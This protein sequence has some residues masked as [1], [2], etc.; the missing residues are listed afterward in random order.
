MQ[1][2]VMPCSVELRAEWI[3]GEGGAEGTMSVHVWYADGG[4]L[5][6]GGTVC[7]KDGPGGLD[8]MRRRLDRAISDESNDSA[9]LWLSKSLTRSFQQ[10]DEAAVAR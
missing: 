9:K 8:D 7:A 1:C 3:Y 6:D 10:V 2:G 4:F 5:T